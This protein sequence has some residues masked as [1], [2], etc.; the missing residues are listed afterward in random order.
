VGNDFL[1]TIAVTVSK[2]IAIA[3]ASRAQ[4]LLVTVPK[5]ARAGTTARN[6]N[7][8]ICFELGKEYE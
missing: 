4:L 3:I 5:I 8:T 2:A 7:G 6:A 1:K